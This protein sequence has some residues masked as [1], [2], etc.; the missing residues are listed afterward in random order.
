[1]PLKQSE[2]IVLRTYPLHE[3]DLLV[4]FF[5]RAE[6]KLKGVAK[7][8]K[9]SRRRF[10]GALEPLTCVRVYWQDRQG[11]ELA[12]IDSC[13]VLLSPLSDELDY[14]RLVALGH[15][16]EML[17]ELMPDR[18]ANDTVFRLAASVLAELA[19]GSIW[20]PVTYFQI[21][22]V[23]LMGFLPELGV[24][25]ECGVEL[26]S[27][28][29]FYHAMV[30]GLLCGRDKR[31][32]SSELSL[33]S[34]RMAAEMFRAPVETFADQRWPRAKGADLRRFLMQIV[35]RHAERKFITVS[36]LEKLE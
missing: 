2:A 11:Q 19:S 29:A 8:A 34:R 3:A 30:D 9:K 31:L 5:T 14:P 17:D 7:A 25:T 33:E 12:R 28:R 6:G 20:M 22:M 10:G 4:T 15:V 24:C 35:Q 26:W 23:R 1:M 27:E 13:D 32:A 18:E 21:W 16:A 36:Q